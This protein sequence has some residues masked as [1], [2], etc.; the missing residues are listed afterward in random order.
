MT[1]VTEEYGFY[2]KLAANCSKDEK[3]GEG[4]GSCS[5]NDSTKDNIELSGYDLPLPKG[6]GATVK[7]SKKAIGKYVMYDRHGMPTRFDTEQEAKIAADKYN[8]DQKVLRSND[9]VRFYFGGNTHVT[10][11]G[12][13]LVSI[14][15]SRY[16]QSV[17]GQIKPD[18]SVEDIHK[19]YK[20][21]TKELNQKIKET[22]NRF[23][24]ERWSEQS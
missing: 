17:T 18:M 21:M 8:H 15:D 22:K 7:P 13:E 4:P 23:T 12:V 24:A 19:M 10:D 20:S 16:G 3:Q 11:M 5:G 1:K 9:P 14:G 2:Q 6:T